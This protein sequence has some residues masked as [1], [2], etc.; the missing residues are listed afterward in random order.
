MDTS[1]LKFPEKEYVC[2]APN[3][4]WYSQAIGS[5][6]YAMPGTLSLL[7]QHLANPGPAHIN[8]PKRVMRYLKGTD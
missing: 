1:K 6:M 2:S 7:S 4:E 3:K 5:F 8:A